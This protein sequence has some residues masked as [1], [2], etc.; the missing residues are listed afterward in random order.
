MD[1]KRIRIIVVE[2]QPILRSEIVSNLCAEG[3]ETFGAKDGT[4]LYVKLLH[5]PADII[6]LDM[7]LS[8]ENGLLI[9][10]QL[11]SIQNMQ[12]LG[13]ITLT[14]QSEP[15]DGLHSL[16]N[17]ADIF[18]VKPFEF[19]EL[20]AYI[21][22]LYR[23]M[24]RGHELRSSLAWQFQQSEWRLVCP[25]GM[26]VELSHLEAAFLS[27][28]GKNA[29]KPMRRKDIISIAFGK[30]PFS[31]DPRRLEA[32]VS[33]LRRKIHLQYPLSQPIKVVHSIGYMFTDVI[34]CI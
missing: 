9:V 3:F 7:S 13:I 29:G 33:R 12:S 26:L 25:S 21:Q 32:V 20:V 18:L 2:D 15:K 5:G 4:E 28:V 16:V 6:I 17:G 11:R 30:D 8:G 1:G 34:R 14:A 19:D 24:Q 31:Y 27:I 22:S 23:R 10:Q